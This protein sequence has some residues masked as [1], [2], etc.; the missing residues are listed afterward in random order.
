LSAPEV[1]EALEPMAPNEGVACHALAAAGWCD[2][3]RSWLAPKISRRLMSRSM[4][5]GTKP[6]RPAG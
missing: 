6:T 5:L 3:P 1:T 2:C 4:A